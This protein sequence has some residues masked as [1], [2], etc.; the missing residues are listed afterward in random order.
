[1]GCNG[2]WNFMNVHGGSRYSSS[3]EIW[4]QR[5]CCCFDSTAVFL[6]LHQESRFPQEFH[7]CHELKY[8]VPVVLQPSWDSLTYLPGWSD[9]AAGLG[10]VHS[11]EWANKNPFTISSFIRSKRKILQ[12]L[13]VTWQPRSGKK[14]HKSASSSQLL[15]KTNSN[16]CYQNPESFTSHGRRRTTKCTVISRETDYHI[17]VHIGLVEKTAELLHEIFYCTCCPIWCKP[18]ATV[19]CRMFRSSG[20]HVYHYIEI[21]RDACAKIQIDRASVR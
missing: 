11:C 16:K 20:F 14:N 1:M 9:L 21:E 7:H 12:V 3:K 18:I 10:E 15:N 8:K 5:C 13:A 17:Q 19:F 6:W 4:V 2:H